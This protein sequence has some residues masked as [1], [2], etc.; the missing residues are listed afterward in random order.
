MSSKAKTL[1]SHHSLEKRNKTVMSDSE[2]MEIPRHVT[3]VK[4]NGDLPKIVIETPWSSAEIY[5]HGA[6]ITH[7]QKI[8]EAPLLFMSA[9]SHFA[10]D[11]P[12]RGGIPIIFPW[13]GPRDGSPAHGFA[14]TRTWD[15]VETSVMASGAV[16]L[17]FHLPNTNDLDVKF[18]VIVGDDLTIE[19]IVKNLSNQDAT[20]ET[21]FHTYFEIGSIDGLSIT[22]LS[23]VSYIDKIA[24]ITTIETATPIRIEQEVDRVY[25]DTTDTVEVIDLDLGR[26]V[27]IEKSGSQSTVV[28]NPWIDKSKRMPDF[29]D[30][31]YLKMV[32]VESGNVG[33][34]QITLQP[35]DI[36]ALKIKVSSE[37]FV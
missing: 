25:H 11:E 9:A 19:L 20:F 18:S 21:C 8:G 14:R 12:I 34:N 13:F 24:E 28:W 6:H 1:I 10:Q 7:F 37:H 2:K 32:C 31:E 33:K 17:Q 35:G 30:D 26:K 5:L 23:G 36:A 22:G 29:G 27:R 3:F 16:Q 15:L 4:G